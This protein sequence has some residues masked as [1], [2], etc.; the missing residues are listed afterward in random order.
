MRPTRRPQLAL[1]PAMPRPRMRSP[2]SP[3]QVSDSSY[4]N[5]FSHFFLV[6][7]VCLYACPLF[8]TSLFAYVMSSTPSRPPPPGCPDRAPSHQPPS[9]RT[10]IAARVTAFGHHHR[11][12]YLHC[13]CYDPHHGAPR[14]RRRP[15]GWADQAAA[16]NWCPG[17]HANR[18]TAETRLSR[19]PAWTTGARYQAI[20]AL[21]RAC[22]PACSCPAVGPE[23]L[24]GC[25]PPESTRLT[26][27]CP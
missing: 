6:Y 3:N 25:G 21:S 9:L 8:S 24:Q 14:T 18:C 20:T 7:F 13:S 5:T 26:V 27:Q 1:I 11:N 16:R 17:H 4:P 10:S 12:E 19:A 23:A 15:L 2:M 22:R